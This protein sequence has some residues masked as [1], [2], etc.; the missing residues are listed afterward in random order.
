M[1]WVINKFTRHLGQR[2]RGDHHPRTQPNSLQA[3]STSPRMVILSIPRLDVLGCSFALTWDIGPGPSSHTVWTQGKIGPHT[4]Y[5]HYYNS[6]TL[7]IAHWYITIPSHCILFTIK[8]Y[9]I[10]ATITA[11]IQYLQHHIGPNFLHITQLAKLK[12]YKIQNQSSI[13][14]KQKSSKISYT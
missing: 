3:C 8:I 7:I 14:C 1:F 2:Y 13:T 4:F 11:T 10:T 12:K 5:L 9:T 6:I